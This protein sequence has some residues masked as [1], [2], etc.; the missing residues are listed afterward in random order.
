MNDEQ[1]DKI[2]REIVELLNKS[3]IVWPK[4]G[5]ANIDELA[6]RIAQKVEDELDKN[7]D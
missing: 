4:Y 6:A 7:K 2:T 5:S 3:D 1:K